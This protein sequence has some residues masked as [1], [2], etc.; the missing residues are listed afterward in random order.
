[1]TVF[2]VHQNDG[3]D[4]FPIFARRVE[5][6]GVRYHA[7]DRFH[8]LQ[9]EVDREYSPFD[10]FPSDASFRKRYGITEPQLTANDVPF[11]KKVATA[12]AEQLRYTRQFRYPNAPQWDL[13]LDSYGEPV[14]SF[15]C[16]GGSSAEF[17]ARLLREFGNWDPPLRLG[18]S[19]LPVPDDIEFP[20]IGPKGYARL[21]VAY[22]LSLDPLNIG[23]V[24]SVSEVNDRHAESVRPTYEDNYVGPEQM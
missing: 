13:T 4:V 9:L 8:A 18:A 11:R 20:G 14:P 1:M 2:N 15:F 24:R 12:I 7:A 19:E 3:E 21:A 22:G 16:G 6:L 23:L 17:Y 10:D 5:P